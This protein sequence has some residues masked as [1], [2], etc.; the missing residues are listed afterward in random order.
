MIW[1]HIFTGII[2]GF[3]GTVIF[4]YLFNFNFSFEKKS[5]NALEKRK[6]KLDTNNQKD[7]KDFFSYSIGLVYDITLDCQKLHKYLEKY[8][9]VVL[10][11]QKKED[12]P[13][14]SESE[15][16]NDQMPYEYFDKY[17]KDFMK[18]RRNR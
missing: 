2:I 5:Q 15:A 10:P 11:K 14:L 1:I 6:V 9:S 12:T 3:L 8:S 17:H 13:Q 18:K 7:L 4:I 16:S